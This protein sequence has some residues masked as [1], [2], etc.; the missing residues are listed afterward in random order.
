MA[1]TSSFSDNF[2]DNSRSASWETTLSNDGTQVFEQN[3]QVEITHTAVA[4]YNTLSTVSTY[5]LT[6]SNFFVE[7]TDVGNQSLT[8]HETQLT[9]YIDGNNKTWI[10]IINNT[11]QVYKL[12]ATVQTQLKQVTWDRR[13]HRW[14]R[15]REASGTTFWE[16]S[17]NPTLEGW[18]LLHSVSNPLTITAVKMALVSG[19]FSNEASAT[20]SKFDNFNIVPNTASEFS[21]YRH[22]EVADGMSR[23]EGAT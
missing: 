16:T 14:I 12:V 4:Q 21:G 10:T 8:S 18:T 1:A 22:L 23:S 9:A 11:V 19:C 15:I 2:N 7:V 5:D 6:G 13:Q 3:G 17:A 20:G